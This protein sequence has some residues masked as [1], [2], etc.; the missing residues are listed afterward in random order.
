MPAVLL[1]RAARVDFLDKNACTPVGADES[2]CSV[3]LQDGSVT[4]RVPFRPTGVGRDGSINVALELRIPDAGGEVVARG[5][6]TIT[7]DN[8]GRGDG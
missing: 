2:R 1:V 7:V 3:D 8:R 6:T 5:R 4:V